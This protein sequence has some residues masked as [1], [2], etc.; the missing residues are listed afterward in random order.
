MKASHRIIGAIIILGAIIITPSF[1]QQGPPPPGPFGQMREKQK[2]TFQLMGMIRDVSVINKNPKYTLSSNQAKRL[3]AV[4]KP[5][6]SK[7]KLTQDQAKT[8]L[9]DVK[10]ILTVNQLNAVAAVKAKPQMGQHRMGPGGPS[11]GG[12]PRPQPGRRFDPN[13]MKDFNP[14]YVKPGSSSKQTF[15]PAK[16]LNDF[17]AALERKA[18]Q[19][20]SAP[21]QKGKTTGKTAKYKK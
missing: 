12:A 6:R 5:L 20:T 2:Y 7:P 9:K 19:S 1:A 15:G 11:S 14:L 16:E 10:K 8:A 17:Y 4:L 21:A 18:K 13:A 3:L